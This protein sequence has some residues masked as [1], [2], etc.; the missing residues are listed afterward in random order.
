VSVLFI[1]LFHEQGR[2]EFRES[3]EIS[4]LPE[5]KLGVSEPFLIVLCFH[6]SYSQGQEQYA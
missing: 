5:K 4:F 1:D 6:P 3:K 2:C